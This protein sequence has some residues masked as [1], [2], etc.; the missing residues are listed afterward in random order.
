M[1]YENSR[2]KYKSDTYLAMDQMI[3]N[4]NKYRK[5]FVG[6]RQPVFLKNREIKEEIFDSEEI[7]PRSE[8]RPG[9]KE[10]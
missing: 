3:K 1:E 8:R 4:I 5:E 9:R 7:T 6:N 10:S 2:I